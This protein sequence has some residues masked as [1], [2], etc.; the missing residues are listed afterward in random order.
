MC[1]I[2]DIKVYSSDYNFSDCQ[3]VITENERVWLDDF[4]WI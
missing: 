4:G 1:D 3:E 2:D